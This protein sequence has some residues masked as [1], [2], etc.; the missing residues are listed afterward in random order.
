MSGDRDGDAQAELRKP[1]V[2]RLSLRAYPFV[3]AIR[4]AGRN[5]G[6]LDRWYQPIMH[7]LG[8]VMGAWASFADPAGQEAQPWVCTAALPAGPVRKCCTGQPQRQHT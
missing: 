4:T 2:R 6:R 1:L 3:T 7:F 8:E 5:I